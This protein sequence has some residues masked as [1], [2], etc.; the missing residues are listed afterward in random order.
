MKIKLQEI[1]N[2][3]PF[4]IGE[5]IALCAC[6]NWK[7]YN[8]PDGFKKWVINS[9]FTKIKPDL[10]FDMHPWENTSSDYPIPDYYEDLK[11]S[12]YDFPIVKPSF[13]N[14]L[15]HQ[16]QIIYPLDEIIKRFGMNLKNSIPEVILYACYCNW[17]YG[18]IIKNIYLFGV[19]QSKFTKFRKWDFHFM[20]Q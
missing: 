7:Y 14:E 15:N 19:S 17:T 13:D 10:L 8:I 20:R 18:N 16:T 4:Y 6:A 3:I 5:N 9:L 12:K 1:E 11:T 2:N